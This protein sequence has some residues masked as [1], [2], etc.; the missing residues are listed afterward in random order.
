[1]PEIEEQKAIETT[2]QSRQKLSRKDRRKTDAVQDKFL[3]ILGSFYGT[4]SKKG[5]QLT[6][7]ELRSEFSK[8]N[9]AWVKVCVNN[10][11]DKKAKALFALE[12]QQTWEK[13]KAKSEAAQ[14]E[15]AE[16]PQ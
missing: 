11:L 10:K 16:A 9:T 5:K 15:T 3:S 8:H 1:M 4:I 12:I 2:K 13:K 7:D 14:K 6:D